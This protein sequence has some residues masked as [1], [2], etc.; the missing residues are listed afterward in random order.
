M[1]VKLNMKS[2]TNLTEAK[3]RTLVKKL[4]KE[5]LTENTSTNLSEE[6][7]DDLYK[8]LD[9]KVQKMSTGTAYYVSDM[10]SSMNKKLADGT[11]NPMYGRILKNTRFIFRWNDTFKRALE[12]QGVEREL[13]TRKGQFEKVEGYELLEKGRSGLYLPILPTGSEYEFTYLK[14]D[15]TSQPISKQEVKKYLRP[16]SPSALEKGP[17]YRLLIVDKIVKL[18]G[19]GN[20]WTNSQFKGTYKGPGTV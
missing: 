2:K 10:T 15:G 17:Q 6:V 13:G 16:P 14:D 7:Y 11:P 19:G 1:K 3:V 8:F 18:T 12:R 5:I 20:I 9:N 4:I